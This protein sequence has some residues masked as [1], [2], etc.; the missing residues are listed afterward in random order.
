[1]RSAAL[2]ARALSAQVDSTGHDHAGERLDFVQIRTAG[3]FVFAAVAFIT[4]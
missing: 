3:R 4:P 1:M 2:A